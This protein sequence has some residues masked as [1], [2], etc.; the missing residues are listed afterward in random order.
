MESKPKFQ[1]RI[2]SEIDTIMKQR[3]RMQKIC[4]E[5]DELLDKSWDIK[6]CSMLNAVQS[7]V[8]LLRDAERALYLD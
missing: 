6:T 3:D 5:L 8:E 4:D 1:A 7:C 2:A